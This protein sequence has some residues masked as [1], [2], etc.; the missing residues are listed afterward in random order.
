MV[1]SFV[2]DC[3]L[4]TP[5][6]LL[7]HIRSWNWLHIWNPP[8]NVLPTVPTISHHFSPSSRSGPTM[9]HFTGSAVFQMISEI[10]KI[11]LCFFLQRRSPK[12]DACIWSIYSV[13][14][15]GIETISTLCRHI[16]KPHI[17][18]NPSL[19]R[20][21]D[22]FTYAYNQKNTQTTCFRWPGCE[23]VNC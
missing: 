20:C 8:N 1:S 4:N 15:A 21:C 14:I 9:N 10:I 19:A 17:I 13:Y 12:S 5:V 11:Y 23:S 2:R 16:C 7:I 6:S 18:P 22:C 3:L